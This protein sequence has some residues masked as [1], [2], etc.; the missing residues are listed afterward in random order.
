MLF[1][2]DYVFDGSAQTP[3]REDAALAPVSAYGRTKAAGEH[4]VRE[5]LPNNHSIVR[6]AW[7]YGAHGSNFV[8]TMIRLESEREFVD[9]VDDQRG[10]PT[11]S[12]DLARQL[13][14][15]V[16]AGAPAGTFHGTNAGETTWFGLAQAVF[17]LCGADPQRV[18]PVTSVQ[19]QRPAPRPAYSVMSHT[20]WEAAGILP[21]RMWDE[22]LRDAWPVLQA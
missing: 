9:V 13:V 6:T 15:L 1:R 12:A 17:E 16:D 5:L 22:A 2:A 3:Y 14:A 8:R 4:A 10:Q 21:M 20:G 18:R 11:W 19:F 7:L